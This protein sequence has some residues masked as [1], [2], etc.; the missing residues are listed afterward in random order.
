MVLKRFVKLVGGDPN[1]KV[2]GAYAEKVIEINALEPDFEAMSDAEL[3]NQ[4]IQF[5]Q[6]LAS[7]ETL[8]DI[9]LEAFATV[10]EASKRTLGM[11]PFDTQL[12]GGMV[13]HDGHIAEMRTGEGKTLTA[14]MPLYLNALTGEGAHLVTVN[15]YLARVQARQMAPLY[16]FLGFNVGLLQMATRTEHG[17][18]A[19]LIDLTR[20]SPHEDQHQLAM[21]DRKQAYDADITY[22][23]N[24]EFGFD[25]LRDNMA[26]DPRTRSQR[27][28]HFAI[29]DEVD[30]VLIDEARTPLI[31]SGPAHDDTDMYVQ[32]AGIVKRLKEEDYEVNEKDR[33]V[34]LTEI[35]ETR[36]EEMLGQPLR[37]PERPEDLT[38]EQSRLMGFLEQALRAQFL[39]KRNKEYLVQ[40]GK[41]V[42]IDE[43]TG[44][45]MPGRRWSD[46][47]HQAVEAKENVKVQSETV[48]YAT[49]TIQNYYRMYEKLAGMTGTALTEAEEFNEIYDLEVVAIPP[50][51]EYMA[52][53]ENSDLN[54]L[55]GFDEY[56]FKYTYYTHK[57]DPE[58]KAVYFKRKDYPDEVYRTVEAK[59]RAI[60]REIIKY[61]IL[62]RPIL[63]GTTSVENSDMLSNLLSTQHVRA[64]LQTMVI[65]HA[66][67]EKNNRVEDGR[68]ILALSPLKE[69]LTRLNA[70]DL[71]KMMQDLDIPVSL[72]NSKIQET[73]L[74]ILGLPVTEE[75]LAQLSK[76]IQGGITHQ[77]LNARK[78]TEESKLIASAG[79]P[80]A[81]TIATNMAGRGV[82]IKLGGEID[83]DILT[84]VNRVLNRSGYKNCYDM[85]MEEREEV[86]KS[87]DTEE[88]KIYA[89]DV[90]AYLD[91]MDGRK[92]VKYAG[93]LHVIGSERHE[94][95]RIDN[96]LR[97]RAARLGDPGSS[98]F[99]LSME[100]DLMRLFGG[101][102]VDSLMQRIGLD[103]A[104]PIAHN[105]VGRIIEQSQTRVEGA[106]FDARKHL[107]EYDDVLNDQRKKIYDQRNIIFEKE[108]LSQNLQELLEE[109]ITIRVPLAM[110][111]DGGPW[112]LLSWLEDIQ[113]NHFIKSHV[114]PSY[115]YKLL[116]EYINENK[117]ESFEQIRPLLM[118]IAR[119]TFA[120]QQEHYLNQIEVQLE[121]MFEALENRIIERTDNLDAFI[122]STSYYDVEEEQ[123]AKEKLTQLSSLLGFG[124]RLEKEDQALLLEDAYQLRDVILKQLVYQNTRQFISRM[125][126]AIERM[127]QSTS[128][129][130]NPGDLASLDPDEIKSSLLFAVEK[131]FTNQQ[132]R[133][134][135]ENGQ[136]SRQIEKQLSDSKGIINTVILVAILNNMTLGS[137][138]GFDPRTHQRISVRTKDLHYIFYAAGFVEEKPDEALTDDVLKHLEKT[139][140]A[141]QNIIGFNEWEVIKDQTFSQLNI[142]TQT[143]L[144]NV[145]TSQVISGLGNQLLSSLDQEQ[146]KTCILMLGQQTVTEVY[147]RILIRVI[148]TLWVDYLTQMEALRVSIALEAYGQRDPLVQYKARAYTMF[149]DLMRDLRQG[150]VNN[151]FKPVYNSP[152]T[153]QGNDELVSAIPQSSSQVPDGEEN[154]N[155]SSGTNYKKKKRRRR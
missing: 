76:I 106:N 64:L 3:A 81:V 136:V 112:K 29:I 14:T 36:V 110:A 42:I 94:A 103:D 113:P 30:N 45:L 129:E 142:R 150:V 21:V 105:L 28:H 97:G 151:M 93:G 26:R 34:I 104:V 99:Y 1:K 115:T 68:A 134:F 10:R 8:D 39:F 16:Q 135:S 123:D 58:Q 19:F 83:E 15:D 78:H 155:S 144:E 152:S 139:R 65:R 101:Q 20:E 121:N 79:A 33:N 48:T 50:I 125:I 100:D 41:V 92:K 70:A 38:P 40:S 32:M 25:Y 49:V 84:N 124:V 154:E 6:R 35:G 22:G 145:L 53:K 87:M 86:L 137:T 102:Q 11:R 141:L 52:T 111:D 71:R 95:R 56:N 147:R 89:R 109:E 140:A 117:P 13:L 128:L 133:L 73:L 5:K 114:F 69:P 131:Y 77:V 62:D 61:N 44:R 72:N 130:L 12:I 43:G 4:T 122:E 88:F 119:S 146:V 108:D 37:D 54:T 75:N 46:G 143:N 31:I 149:Q 24:N 23:T 91:H 55:Q 153:V 67:L 132:E 116:L 107:L 96:Q 18:K 127:L 7:G 82:D 63:V 47:L 59:F 74:V 60:M 90:Q 98:R 85:T 138:I 9:M 118:E 126:F 80:G 148:D 66:W 57:D 2:I 27:G 120:A 51:V 17:R